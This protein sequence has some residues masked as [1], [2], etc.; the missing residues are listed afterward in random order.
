MTLRLGYY[1]LF[2]RKPYS[3]TARTLVRHTGDV[4]WVN[5]YDLFHPE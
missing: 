4:F 2:S 5:P 1:D 3:N